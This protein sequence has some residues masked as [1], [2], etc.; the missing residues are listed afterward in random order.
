MYEAL[1]SCWYCLPHPYK[2]TSKVKQLSKSMNTPCTLSLLGIWALTHK[3]PCIYRESY[4]HQSRIDNRNNCSPSLNHKLPTETEIPR[5]QEKCLSILYSRALSTQSTLNHEKGRE[6]CVLKT[7]YMSGVFK[8]YSYV[9]CI[10]F[11][12]GIFATSRIR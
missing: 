11:M 2:P 4:T 5:G 12:K 9:T 1:N 8:V 3:V 7:Y 10:T 6:E